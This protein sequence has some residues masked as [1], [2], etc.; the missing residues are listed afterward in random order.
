MLMKI[1]IN[2]KVKFVKSLQ[3][4]FKFCMM[5]WSGLRNFKR[6]ESL[7]GWRFSSIFDDLH[8]KFEISLFTYLFTFLILKI[9]NK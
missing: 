2:F 7:S 8:G 3:G 9:L 6:A 1:K 5:I 4:K